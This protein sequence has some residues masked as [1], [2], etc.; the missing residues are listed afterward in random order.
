MMPASKVGSPV[1]PKRKTVQAQKDFAAFGYDLYKLWL[2][3]SSMAKPPFRS[4]EALARLAE[5]Y[6]WHPRGGLGDVTSSHNPTLNSAPVADG[7]G[8]FAEEDAE[9]EEPCVASL[10]ETV[11]NPVLASETE[12]LVALAAAGAEPVYSLG[13]NSDPAP[14]RQMHT[15]ESRL[16][17]LER[18]SR[19]V[20]R[21]VEEQLQEPDPAVGNRGLPGLISQ[22][23]GLLTE[24]AREQASPSDES[25]TQ[26]AE[27]GEPMV[28]NT[29]ALADE[30]VF[31][32]QDLLSLRALLAKGNA[33]GTKDQQTEVDGSS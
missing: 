3:Y 1:G 7:S 30:G 4:L 15:A 8:A 6:D 17:I 9:Y 28:L 5:K 13:N 10:N 22:L 2:F 21:R 24:L 25:P 16:Q 32:E 23:R 19:K 26:Q 31:S 27:T 29:L 12:E 18:L 14:V 20:Q 33:E 11:T